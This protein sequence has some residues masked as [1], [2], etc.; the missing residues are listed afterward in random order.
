MRMNDKLIEL[1]DYGRLIVVTDLHG[2][3]DDYNHYLSLWDESE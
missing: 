3:L 2:D 1:P